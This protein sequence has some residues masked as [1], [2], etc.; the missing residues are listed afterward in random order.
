MDYR[1]DILLNICRPFSKV[2]TH[3]KEVIKNITRLPYAKSLLRRQRLFE[4]FANTELALSPRCRTEADVMRQ[5]ENYECIVCGSDQTWNLDPAGRYQN[6]VYY[7]NFPKK[8]RRVTYATSFG[9]WVK[10]LPDHEDEVLPWIKTYDMLSMRE[11][12]GAAYLRSKGFDCELVLDPTLLLESGE[13]S[14]IC[15]EPAERDYVLL[16]SWPGSKNAV[17]IT[18]MVSGKLGVKPICIVPPP[19]TMFS[20]IERKLDVGPK[21]FLGLVKNAAFVVTD[22]FHGTVFSIQYEKPF[23]SVNNGESDTRRLSLLDRLGLSDHYL[24]PDKL[25]FD[26]ILSTDFASAKQKL[27]RLRDDSIAYLQ[28]AIGA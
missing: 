20:G 27:L 21:E 5:A 15:A 10:K 13:Y 24:A 1:S 11:E 7:L 14:S 22:S 4:L 25:D 9:N 28:R 18:N 26:K 16:F 23:V 6:A 19:R 8:Q 3:P 17:M 2:P 12:S